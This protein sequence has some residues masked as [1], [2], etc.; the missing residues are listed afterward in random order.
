MQKVQNLG[1]KRRFLCDISYAR[2]A[3]K[4]LTQIYKALYGDA[5]CKENHFKTCHLDKLNLAF[6]SPDVISTSPKSFLISRINFCYSNSSKKITCPSGKLKTEFTCPIAES[7][8]PGLSDTTFFACWDT[9]FVSLW[10]AQNNMAAGNKQN[11]L[12]LI[13]PTNGEFIAW[14]THKD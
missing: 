5:G 12:S 1:N 13:F 7:T 10:G 14:G 11:H 9:M 2:Y 3:E 6:T 8:S 4:H